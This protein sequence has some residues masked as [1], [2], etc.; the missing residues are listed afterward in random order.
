MG[1]E[2]GGQVRRWPGDR[3]WGC[4]AVSTDK[5][6]KIWGINGQTPQGL[7]TDQSACEVKWEVRK[8]PQVSVSGNEIGVIIHQEKEYKRSLQ[9]AGESVGLTLDMLNSSVWEN[10]MEWSMLVE[11]CLE[12]GREMWT[13]TVDLGDTN[14]W[15]VVEAMGEDA[16]TQEVCVKR[17][18]MQEIPAFKA[19]VEVRPGRS[20]QRDKMGNRR[21][22][23]LQK[24]PKGKESSQK[25]GVGTSIKPYPRWG[26]VRWR[27]RAGFYS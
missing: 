25:K 10:P 20:G 15:V 1:R 7:V 3:W 27:V 13:E 19:N 2:I 11:I 21:E 18:E 8:N 12:P 26:Q 14:T 9:C 23:V 24:S 16:L 17:G 6:E 4:W 5:K 22:C